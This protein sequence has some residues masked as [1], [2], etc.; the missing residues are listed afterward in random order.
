MKQAR[1]GSYF[2]KMCDHTV[3][4]DVKRR[5]IRRFRQARSKYKKVLKRTMGAIVTCGVCA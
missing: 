2:E 5:E 4:D 1:C 3:V